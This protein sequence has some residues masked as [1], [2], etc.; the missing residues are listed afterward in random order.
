MS[1]KKV[2]TDVQRKSQSQI[3]TICN[4]WVTVKYKKLDGSLAD[5][6]GSSYVPLF[7]QYATANRKTCLIFHITLA[8]PTCILG[9]KFCVYIL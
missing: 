3:T 7:G 4:F 1:F 2:W 5:L 8:D 9:T 6:V